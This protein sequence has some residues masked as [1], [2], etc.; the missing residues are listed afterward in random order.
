MKI[1][2]ITI[3][4][5]GNNFGS[6]LQACAMN[7]FIKNIGYEDTKLINYI[8][9]Y[10]NNKGYLAQLI[11][12]ILF[13]R[14][15]RIQKKRFMDYFSKHSNLTKKYTKYQ[16]LKQ[17][18]DGDLYIVGSDQL[19]NEFYHAG[20]DDA[21]YLKFTNCKNKMSYSASLGQLHTEE[22]LKR[23][24][25]KIQDFKF[26]ALREQASVKQFEDYKIK[27]AVHVLDPVF[28]FDKNYYIDS[29]Y[30]NIYGDYLLV[31]TVNNSELLDMVVKKVS[32]KL[33]L[34]I[35]L[36]GGYLQ[37]C[38]NDYYLRDIGPYEFVNLINNAKYVIANSF[39]ATAMSIILNKQFSIVL[40][41]NS[42]MRL[43]DM[44][45]VA[46]IGDRVIKNESKIDLAFD[47]IDYSH[48]NKV[49]DKKRK[50][51]QEYLINSIN[52][53]SKNS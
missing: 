33:K 23:I 25:S 16:Q 15:Y 43:I 24:G 39:H 1:R 51:S 31:Y 42:P 9:S 44:L 28:L 37:K 13:F 47:E 5:L 18:N 3:H 19:W 32:E 2:I 11:K 22:T 30:K 35:V 10:T 49:I 41:N 17:E 20:R 46:E 21:Y 4:D 29:N 53:F 45:M 6:T 48:V 7:E 14:D 52:Y 38:P 50:E 12:K 8:P 40:P 27:N 26:V 36:V 34:K